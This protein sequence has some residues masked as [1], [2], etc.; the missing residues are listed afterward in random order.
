MSHLQDLGVVRYNNPA[1]KG[2]KV[3]LNYKT[4]RKHA[5]NDPLGFWLS[6]IVNE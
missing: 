2:P 1:A 4:E 6:V 5:R 3:A